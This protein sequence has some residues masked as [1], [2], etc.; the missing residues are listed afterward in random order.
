M[1]LTIACDR[2]WLEVAQHQPSSATTWHQLADL[3]RLLGAEVKLSAIDND[4]LSTYVATRR[5]E[6]NRKFKDKKKAPFISP[7]SVNRE[8]ELM[9][10]VMRKAHKVWNA[11]VGEM[12][13]WGDL[14]LEEPAA[15]ERE[16]GASEE[17][18]LFGMLRSDMHA[19]VQFCIK[20]GMRKMNAV[21][22][23]WPQV[24]FD[25]GIIRLKVKSTSPGGKPHIV[26]MTGEVR[27]LLLAERGRHESFVFTYVCKRSRH[28]RRKG[29]RY[30]FSQ[31]GWSREW[32]KSLEAARIGDFR[33]HDTRHTAGTRTLRSSKNMRAVQKMLGHSTITSTARYA[34]ALVDDVRDAMESVVESRKIPEVVKIGNAKRLKNKG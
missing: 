32:R 27:A 14:F 7:S 34:H 16:L 6:R 30:Q 28:K 18:H 9:R 8:I 1:S 21:R 24:D 12:P 29:Q 33:F 13:D 26:P 15:R 20:T 11:D 5:G 17:R 31:S 22:L 23:T 25:A 3:T 2:Y 4:A 19:L 10:Q